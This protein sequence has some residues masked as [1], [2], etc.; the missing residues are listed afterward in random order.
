MCFSRT[1]K[2]GKE[3]QSIVVLQGWSRWRLCLNWLLGMSTRASQSR[4][5]E[6]EAELR[7]QKDG[8]LVQVLEDAAALQNTE[9]PHAVGRKGTEVATKL[10]FLSKPSS[11]AWVGAM[12]PWLGWGIT[13]G[14]WAS[15]P[16]HCRRNFLKSQLGTT[17]PHC[18]F[19]PQAGRPAAF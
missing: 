5:Q 16:R 10:W 17:L 13:A 6:G 12:A 19:K 2:Q 15:L 7:N 3:T 11:E 18:K 14:G 9:K 1:H 4:G 8:A